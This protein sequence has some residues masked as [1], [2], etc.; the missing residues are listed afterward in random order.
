[1]VQHS[2]PAF[3]ADTAQGECCPRVLFEQDSQAQDPREDPCRFLPENRGDQPVQSE[4]YPILRQ[5]CPSQRIRNQRG[6]LKLLIGYRQKNK[7]RNNAEMCK[8]VMYVN[9]SVKVP[10]RQNRQHASLGQVRSNRYSG[11]N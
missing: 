6:M 4:N 9:Q 10:H 11:Y 3:M 5:E 1:M 8:T 2:T 7:L